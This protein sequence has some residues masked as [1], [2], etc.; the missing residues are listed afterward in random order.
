[1]LHDVFSNSVNV[2]F[3]YKIFLFV[4]RLLGCFHKSNHEI[5]KIINFGNP[6][7]MLKKRFKVNEDIMCLLLF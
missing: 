7:S 3:H 2:L 5:I 6:N 1:M 4:N